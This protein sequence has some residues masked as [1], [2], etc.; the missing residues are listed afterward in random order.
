MVLQ[1]DIAFGPVGCNLAPRFGHPLVHHLAVQLDSIF[2]A[3]KG[4]F[5]MIPLAGPERG[6]FLGW[7]GIVNRTGGMKQRA[8][9]C[10]FD[11]AFMPQVSFL[12]QSGIVDL[13]LEAFENIVVACRYVG[14]ADK[15]T[16]IGVFLVAHE[17]HFEHEILELPGAVPENAHTAVRGEHAGVR[18]ESEIAGAVMVPAVLG[19][20]AS[21]VFGQKLDIT[22]IRFAAGVLGLKGTRG[23]ESE[24][25]AEHENS[26]SQFLVRHC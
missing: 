24:A 9:V 21:A 2:Q 5:V 22:V 15:D 1:A 17:I 18:V 20:L 7:F 14:H 26:E 3:L 12:A 4:Y 13:Y 23:A 16:G 19:I 10:H 11:I 6:H 25:Q 8:V